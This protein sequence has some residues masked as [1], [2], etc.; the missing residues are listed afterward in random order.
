M[1]NIIKKIANEWNADPG[2]DLTN[3]SI[4]E[5]ALNTT[6]SKDY[7]TFLQW[8]NGGEGNIGDNYISLWKCEDLIT[9]NNE[10]QIQKY[11]S[12]KFL[13]IGT[14]SLCTQQFCPSCYFSLPAMAQTTTPSGW[15]TNFIQQI[16]I[17]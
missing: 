8:S 17:L 13:G 7:I 10:Y 1:E 2:A 14:D 12:N 9:L 11:L 4:I 6:F 5:K 16:Q 3:I 15:A